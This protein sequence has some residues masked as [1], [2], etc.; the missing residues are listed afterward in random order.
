MTT[1]THYEHTLLSRSHNSEN[2]HKQNFYNRVT[3]S[4]TEGIK[5]YVPSH[6]TQIL[7]WQILWS[8]RKLFNKFND[9]T[10]QVSS[11]T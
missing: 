8:Q 11:A 6:M 4:L 10:S 3:Q 7:C 2:G 1:N 9:P 5:I